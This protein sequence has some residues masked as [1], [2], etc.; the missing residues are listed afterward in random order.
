MIVPIIMM[1]IAILTAAFGF[2]ALLFGYKANSIPVKAF[3]GGI[4]L[5]IIL[6]IPCICCGNAVRDVA[7]DLNDRYEMLSTY[8]RAVD[9]CAN[10]YIRFDFYERCNEYNELYDRYIQLSEGSWL[11]AFYELDKIANCKKIDFTLLGG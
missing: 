1:T 4:I 7:N 6:S 8:Q 9:N 3:F 5:F 2:V 11:G 10:E